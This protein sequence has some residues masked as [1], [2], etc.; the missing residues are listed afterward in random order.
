MTI[1][2]RQSAP[3]E[4]VAEVVRLPRRGGGRP[5]GSVG[6]LSLWLRPQIKRFKTQGANC[7]NVFRSLS[8]VE[9]GD[10]QSFTVSQE[11]A[12]AYYLELGVDIAGMTVTLVN[13]K[14]IWQRT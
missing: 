10:G 3:A 5:R 7:I 12:D 1:S 2:L 8:V 9:G 11:T 4:Q 13:F 6:P 14:K